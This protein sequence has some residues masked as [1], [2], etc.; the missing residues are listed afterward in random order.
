M[1]SRGG[2]GSAARANSWRPSD[3]GGGGRGGW[4]ALREMYHTVC[5]WDE[6]CGFEPPRPSNFPPARQARCLV[7]RGK[8]V[9]IRWPSCPQAAPAQVGRSQ[10]GKSHRHCCCC[11]DWSRWDCGRTQDGGAKAHRLP[12]LA[13]KTVRAA[14]FCEPASQPAERPAGLLGRKL[15]RGAFSGP[16]Q[17]AMSGRLGALSANSSR[18]SARASLARSFVIRPYLKLIIFIIMH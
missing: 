10:L 9:S 7:A 4:Q 11:P 2:R 1:D 6:R 14:T 3:G 5:V 18:R 12:C 16:N 17:S 8:R 13:G 15:R